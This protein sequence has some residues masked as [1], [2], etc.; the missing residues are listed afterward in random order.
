MRSLR[1]ALTADPDIPVP[2]RLYGGI[3]RVVD[4]L[5]RHLVD[6]GHEV[7]LF[8]HP[9]S[10]TAGMLMP[11]PAPNDGQARNVLRNASFLAR[12]V[13][14]GGFD[15]VHSF[16]RIAYLS[17]LLPLSIPKLMSFQREITARTV[18]LGH[19]LG[20]G[21]LEFTAVSRSLLRQGPY[22][23]RWSVVP[24]ATPLERYIFRGQVQPDAPLVFLGRIEAIKGPQLAIEIARRSGRRL[25]IAG[26]VEPDQ[27]AWFQAHIAPHLDG[28]LIRYVGPVDDEQKN[29]LLGEAAALLMPILWEEPFGIV[30]IEAMAC[31]TPVLALSRGAAPEVVADGETGFLRSS[32]GDLAG[33]VQALPT[34]DRAACRARVERLY[35][36]AAVGEAYT[37]LYRTAIA[38]RLGP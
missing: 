36:A 13:L 37:T 30:I 8:A 24:N 16:S 11:W 19:T 10:Q 28:E 20:R 14:G 32:T 27:Q 12:K 18:R 33:S 23:G 34:L 5:A 31:G 7:A 22:A 26:N 4:L 38:R 29:A 9:G 6:H 35:S 2:P 21:S 15:L 1:I 3:E 25:V 17:P